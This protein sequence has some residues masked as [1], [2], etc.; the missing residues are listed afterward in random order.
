MNKSERANGNEFEEVN[1]NEKE[2]LCANEFEKVDAKEREWVSI[3]MRV[4]ATIHI[5]NNVGTERERERDWVCAS[6]FQ[7]LLAPW[8]VG[9]I[10]WKKIWEGQGFV[11]VYNA[12]LLPPKK[13]VQA[14]SSSYCDIHR[15]RGKEKETRFYNWLRRKKRRGDIED[16]QTRVWG[17]KTTREREL[18]RG[19]MKRKRRKDKRIMYRKKK[20]KTL[21]C[22][23]NYY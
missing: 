2:R 14:K 19:V 13:L 4:H 3:D 7:R 10:S 17:G 9:V 5:D 23:N 8:C 1:V 11:F 21:R 18:E 15:E 6:V 22:C 20:N 12:I 16:R